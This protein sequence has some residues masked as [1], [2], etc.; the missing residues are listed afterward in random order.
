M[1]ASK[2]WEEFTEG[3]SYKRAQKFDSQCKTNVDM[4]E[5]RQWPPATERTKDLPRPVINIIEQIGY[6]KCSTIMADNIMMTFRPE[7]MGFE[8]DASIADLFSKKAATDWEELKMNSKNEKGLMVAYSR[9]NYILHHY[10]DNDATGGRSLEYIGKIANEIIDPLNFFPGNPK[11]D[12]VQKQP[13]IIIVTRVSVEDIKATAK[14]K[15]IDIGLIE[16]IKPDIA[17]DGYGNKNELKGDDK[18]TVLV[19]YW[20]DKTSKTIKFCK[21]TKS[22]MFVPETDTRLKLYP[23]A[24]M[25]WKYKEDSFFGENDVTQIIPNQKAINFMLAM[26]I[27]SVQLTGFPKALVREGRIDLSRLT[28]TPGEIVVDYS[29]DENSDA[30]KYIYPPSMSSDGPNLVDNLMGYTKNIA[31]ATETST[32]EVAKAANMNATAI[33]LLQ[34]AAGVPIEGIKRRF[35]QMMEDVGLIWSDIYQTYYNTERN[36]DAEDD[37][38]NPIQIPFRGTDYQD[39]PFRLKIEISPASMYSE[40]MAQTTLDKFFDKGVIDLDEYLE[41]VPSNV[42]PFKDRL[43]RMIDKKKQEQMQQQQQMPQQDQS[44]GM[45]PQEMPMAG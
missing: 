6:H 29:P 23:V 41:L 11:C 33:M 36:I 13:Y 39:V 7:E 34:K 22:V 25:Q 16:A 2:V 37:D 14:E 10:M 8:G 40:T 32:G 28:N 21:C 42:A 18:A 45:Q 20:R 5:G 12:D 35:Y 1:D 3:M 15:K 43:K 27:L 31:G 19:R 26:Q 4:L 17:E 24:S 38:G 9:S 44:Q 30:M